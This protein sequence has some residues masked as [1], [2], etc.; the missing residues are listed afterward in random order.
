MKPAW[1]SALLHSSDASQVTQW[2][3]W[4]GPFARWPHVADLLLALLALLLTLLLWSRQ[5]H[6]VLAL[7]SF[8]D[9]AA[10]QC[11]FIA[12]FALLW[13]RSH[14][15]QVHIVIVLA[16][17]VL[18]LG[19]PAEGLVALAFSLF[20]LG[21]YEANNRASWLAFMAALLYL[22][23]DQGLL[24]RPTVSGTVATMLGW[25]LWYS[26]RRLR[27]RGEYLRLLEERAAALERERHADAERAV[28]AERTRIAREMH[29]VVA[30]QLSMMTV[31]AGAARTVIQ[32]NPDAAREAMTA[33]EAAGRQALKEMRQLLG[34]LRPA[35]E[36]AQHSPQPGLDD[37]SALI[38]QVRSVV[39]QL[40][41][42]ADANLLNQP[43]SANVALAAYRIVQESLTNIVKHVGS[44]A[45]VDV[46][47][48]IIAGHLDIQVLNHA[49]DEPVPLNPAQT[50]GLGIQGMQERVSALGGQLSAGPNVKGGFE[51]RATLPITPGSQ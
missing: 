50:A 44:Q 40:N 18:E 23:I 11:A 22:L 5:N 12:S 42:Q 7:Q 6:S 45:Q 21:R 26:G 13:R 28:V 33:V 37:L 49:L 3:P 25:A 20:A 43:L 16:S 32:S 10:F 35:S 30:H 15:W 29:D 48:N 51:V 1:L 17:V 41:Y 27:F 34:V 19:L 36:P 46:C 2:R 4:R 39:A 38:E 31:Q 9:I 14:P 24:Q 47:V 8:V